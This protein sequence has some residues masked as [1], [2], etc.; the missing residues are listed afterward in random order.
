MD[1]L[2]QRDPQTE[3]TLGM[4]RHMCL[5]FPLNSRS[6]NKSHRG[7][8]AAWLGQEWEP[9][10]GEF[11]GKA[12]REKG[13][14]SLKGPSHFDPF[15]GIT[16]QST[17]RFMAPT[18]LDLAPKVGQAHKWARTGLDL[19]PGVTLDRMN[20]R[21]SLLEQFDTA[22]IDLNKTQS[23]RSFNRFQ[24]MAFDMITSPICSTALDVTQEPTA[25]RDKYGYTLFGQAAL[26]ARRLVEAGTRVV[27]VY[28]DEYGPANTAWD[29]HVNNFPRLKEGLCPTLDQV[30]STLLVD[31]DQ[32]GMLDET[33]VLL[34]S[35][36]GRTPKIGKK[37]GG[38]RE[39]WSHAYCGLFAGAGI[40][41]G[42]VI[43]ATDKQAAYPVDRPVNPKDILA[44]LYHLM[45]ID[46]ETARTFD[47]QSRPHHLLPYGELVPEMIG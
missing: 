16:P 13:F 9:V 25:L 39:H 36:H 21:H 7:L 4:P 3:T 43:G 20:R 41:R 1:Y 44:T 14:P 24:Q 26:A 22:R 19:Q 46:T 15:D 27:T 2:W 10:F 40:Q 8:T 29:T 38:S 23:S 12:S 35:E 32:R 34:M 28:W 33:V 11:S 5:P 31:L 30:Y 18:M 6:S 47:R 17:F 42:Q 45:G 37:P